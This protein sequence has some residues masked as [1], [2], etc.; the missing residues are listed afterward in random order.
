MCH[1]ADAAEWEESP[2]V[3][4]AT[5]QVTAETDVV[6]QSC[7]GE[8]VADHPANGVLAVQ[9]VINT[10][11]QSVE[12]ASMTDQVRALATELEQTKRDNDSL[13]ATSVVSLGFGLGIGAMLGAIGVFVVSRWIEGKA[14]K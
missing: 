3:H 11:K 4:V 6:C 2:H 10:E 5:E 8:Y 9:Q 12:M 13:K 14:R 7:H 1:P